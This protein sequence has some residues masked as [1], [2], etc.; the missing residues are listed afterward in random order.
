MSRTIPQ[1]SRPRTLVRSR[2]RNPLPAPAPVE[3]NLIVTRDATF[4]E[5]ERRA[6]MVAE[7]AYFRAEKRSFDPNHELD[8]WLA[9]EAEIGRALLQEE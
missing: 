5:P 4:M 9:A 3:P 7:C 2:E 6:A 1:R 8:D